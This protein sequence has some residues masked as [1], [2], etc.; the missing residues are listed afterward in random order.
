MTS[1]Q[2]KPGKVNIVMDGQWGSAGK[3]KVCGYAAFTENVVAS[4]CS[5]MVNAG[6]WFRSNYYGDFLVQQLPMAA[7]NPNIKL[8]MSSTCGIHVPTLMKEIN[9][10]ES[11]G[12][13]VRDRLVID[14]LA[15][16]IEQRHAVLEYAIGSGTTYISSTQKGCGAALAEKVRRAESVVLARDVPELQC[17]LGNVSDIVHSHLMYGD[18]VMGEMAQGFDLSLNHGTSYPYVTSR[19]VTPMSFLND[20][21]VPPKYLGEVIG[22]IRTFP[23]RVGSIDGFTSGPMHED[24]H[25]VNWEFISSL[26]GRNTIEKTTVTQRVRRVFTFSDIQLSRY[27]RVCDPTQLFLTFCDYLPGVNDA[28]SSEQIMNAVKDVCSEKL[29]RSKLVTHVSTGPLNEQNRKLLA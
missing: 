19:D 22:V 15:V 10:F 20:I 11:R 13:P 18:V 14:P 3:G 28:S 4:V 17:F 29:Y 2:F 5:F 1:L 26:S 9:L 16:I 12:I 6:H 21:G 23:I 7:V 25:E 27:L 24:Q 8:L